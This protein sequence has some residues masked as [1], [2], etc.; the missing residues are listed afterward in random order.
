[1]GPAATA[2]EPLLLVLSERPSH[3]G[4]RL[5]PAAA[6]RN[7]RRHAALACRAQPV[8]AQPFSELVAAAASAG[9]VGRLRRICE[10]GA[11]ATAL[12]GHVESEATASMPTQS[13]GHGTRAEALGR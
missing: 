6:G 1:P 5:S 12:C 13:R 4:T 10:S 7:P 8:F 11:M 3:Q 2:S 9:G